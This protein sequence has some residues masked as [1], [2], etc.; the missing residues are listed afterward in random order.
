MTHFKN[1]KTNLYNNGYSHQW[2]LIKS[3]QTP[4]ISLEN[5]I[6][7]DFSERVACQ[8]K[9]PLCQNI[10]LIVPNKIRTQNEH[11]QLE[12]FLQIIGTRLEKEPIK[13]NEKLVPMINMSDNSEKD[14]DK[15]AFRIQEFIKTEKSYV[16]TL[17]TLMKYVVNPL[18]SM[19]HHKNCIINT[20]KCTKIFLNIDQIA[21]ANEKFLSDLLQSY[22]FG[23]ICQKHMESFECYRKYLL[24]QGDAQK[25]HAKEFKSNQTYRRFLLKAKDHPEFKKRRLQDILVEPVQR[26][27][28]YSM[29]LR[30]I[31]NLTPQDHPDYPGLKLAC[32]K[33]REIATMDDDDPTKTATMLLSLYQTIKESPCSLVSQNRS[34]VAHLDALEIHS[35]TNKP[36]R[37]VTLFLFTDKILVASRSSLDEVDIE[38]LLD[39]NTTTTTILSKL[40]K[41]GTLRFKGWADIESIELFDGVLDRP[42]SF[43]LSATNTE[44]VQINEISNI[45]SFEHYFYKGPRLFAPQREENNHFQKWLDFKTLY[46]KTRAL[47][48][49]YEPNDMTY[50]RSWNGI[51]TFCNIYD[52]ETYT[53]VKYKNNCAIVYVDDPNISTE[54]LF[55]PSSQPWI[56][57][58]IQPEEMKGFRFNLC[59][60]TGFAN[61]YRDLAEMSQEQHTFD[62]ESVFWNNVFFLNQSLR[63]SQEYMERT[64]FLMQQALASS[65]MLPRP[66]S[67]SVSRT[68]SIPSLGKLFSSSEDTR[69]PTTSHSS[70][71]K[72]Y[73]SLPQPANQQQDKRPHVHSWNGVPAQYINSPSLLALSSSK[74]SEDEKEDKKHDTISS[75]GSSSTSS[76]FSMIEDDDEELEQ[77]INLPIAK[78]NLKKSYESL[79]NVFKSL[80]GFEDE[81]Q[82]EWKHLVT[83][84]E[85]LG[86]EINNNSDMDTIE[87]AYSDMSKHITNLTAFISMVHQH[88]NQQQ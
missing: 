22:D 14:D 78:M 79:E 41:D 42:S 73:K 31:L 49:Q 19:T 82:Q 39:T 57:G 2:K 1:L 36:L 60:K 66:R 80:Q 25:L 3:T 35:V 17:Q 34:F 86:S 85:L 48:K 16:E 38:E 75:R 13:R 70:D 8:T 67:R 12:Q 6:N 62:F 52:Q 83:K 43:I 15:R 40:K 72:N 47:V 64:T 5:Q 20:F 10:D 65:I 76:S 55:P 87:N 32:E 81:M 4:I 37:A 27:S 28:R 84:Y 33:S 18:R 56:I 54:M 77:E 71:K 63:V 69:F 29:M 50:Y 58:L 61:K 11:F 24:E 23:S 53:K 30:E 74:L 44:E 9:K 7:L 26:I 51:S 46:Q 68:T 21:C 59:T 45:T 88:F